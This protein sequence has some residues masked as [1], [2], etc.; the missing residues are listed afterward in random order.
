MQ[1]RCINGKLISQ[2]NEM[3]IQLIFVKELSGSPENKVKDND[4]NDQD[5]NGPNEEIFFLFTVLPCQFE[6]SF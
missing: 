3:P 6:F 2:V 4:Q 5:P 1:R